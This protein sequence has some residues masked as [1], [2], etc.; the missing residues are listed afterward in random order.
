MAWEFDALKHEP[1]PLEK[2]PRCGAV[3]MCFLRG[4]VHNFWRKLFCLEYSCVICQNCKE[5][6]GY[7]KPYTFRKRRRK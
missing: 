7:E 2:C 6:V 4:M 5:V 1:E 3:F